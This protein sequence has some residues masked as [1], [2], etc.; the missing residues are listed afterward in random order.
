MFDLNQ[1]IRQWRENL[2][3]QPEFRAADLDELEDHLREGIAELQAAGLNQEEA[4]LVAA[5][6]LGDPKALASEFAM[7]SPDQRRRFRLRW[8]VV[9]ALALLALRLVEGVLANLTYGGLA[10]LPFTLHVT[11]LIGGGVR[12]LVI[13]LGGLLIWRL[14]AS[15]RAARGVGRLGAL[16]R[17]TLGS[18]VVAI[19]AIAA[20]VVGGLTLGGSRLLLMHHLPAPDDMTILVSSAWFQTIV[21]L[22]LPILLIMLLWQM[23]RPS[24]A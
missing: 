6:R 12:F 18:V 16:T 11:G 19:L 21:S 14:L 17:V 4:F 3:S 5:R 15:D 20:V 1:T 7:A 8:M 10:L 9:G 23:V 13:L 2:A 24:R 22:L